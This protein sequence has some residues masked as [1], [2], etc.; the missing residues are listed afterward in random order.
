MVSES[1]MEVK[2]SPSKVHAF[3]LKPL[4]AGFLGFGMFLLILFVL[5]LVRNLVLGENDPLFEGEDLLLATIGF[6]LMWL[7]EFLKNFKTQ[8]A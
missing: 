2:P 8:S 7:L 1:H 4:L 6:I 5:K 3:V